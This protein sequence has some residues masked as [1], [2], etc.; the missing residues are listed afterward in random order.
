MKKPPR[1]R[2]PPPPGRAE[3]SARTERSQPE[4]RSAPRKPR[5]PSAL[6][7]SE[8]LEARLDAG[9]PWIYRDHVPT[10]FTARAGEFVHLECGRFD[11]YALWDQDSPIALRVFS[12][13]QRPDAGWVKARLDEAWQLRQQLL[14]PHTNAFRLLFGEG[15]ALPGIVVDVYAGFAIIVS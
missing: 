9:H 6:V 12:R 4:A 14:P 1:D 15:D 2:R 5:D 10:R 13:K 3:P 8:A 7:L 11:G